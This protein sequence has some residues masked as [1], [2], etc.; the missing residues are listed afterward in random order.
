VVIQIIV[1][2]I[3]KINKIT[4]MIKKTFSQ[5][6]FIITIFFAFNFL[7]VFSLDAEKISD[8]S[9]EISI[10]EIGFKLP[11]VTAKPQV[12]WHWLNGHISSKA[13]TQDLE[14][15]KKT[16]IGG[17][18]LF[19]VSEG[20]PE[21][22][23]KYMSD[24]WWSLLK[25]TKAE[26]KR[27]GLE[28]GFHNG[29]GW[30]SSGG[31]WVT[32]DKAMQEVVWT[33]KKITGPLAFD[34]VLE[35]N[36]AAIGIDRDMARNP[37]V[38]KRY[39]VA[40]EIVEGYYNDIVL[41]AFP[42]PKREIKGTPYLI[43]DWKAKSGYTKMNSYAI[44]NRMAKDSDLIDL[45]QII[46]L[47][48]KLDSNGRLKWDVPAGN[49]TII[50]FGY[51]PT[52]RSNHPAPPAGK[53]LEI[54]KLSKE[55]VDF[56][57]EKSISKIIAAGSKEDNKTLQHILI[58]SYEVGH[59]NWNSTF[60]SDFKKM[61][62]YSLL[63]YLPAL[64][65]RVVENMQTSEKFL[66]DFR[67][68]ISE[69]ITE[70]YYSHFASLAEKNGLSLSAEAY[71][72]FGNINDFDASGKV[73]TPM[74]EWWASSNQENHTATAKLAASTA[75]TY[76]RKLAGAE[77]FTG[78][79]KQ[80]FEESPRSLK[81]EGDFF[82][83]L[84]I[85]QFNLHGF[86]HDPYNIP[87]GLGLGTYGSRFDRR[88]TWC[89]YA[90]GWFDYLSRCQYMLQQGKFKAD[91]LYYVGED[92]PLISW[93]REKLTPA[94]PLGYDYDF[95]NQE[96]LKQLVVKKGLIVLP[97]GMTYRVLILP[98]NQHMGLGA[99]K[100]IEHLVASGATIVGS[101]PLRTP[102]LEGGQ[103]AEEQFKII[104]GRLWGNCDGKSITENKYGKGKIYWGKT[105][106]NI[107]AEKNIFP[108]LSFKI[109]SNEKFGVLNHSVSGIEFIHRQLDG[110]DFY[111]VSNQ[112]DKA[113]LVE[114]TFRVNS[115]LP[116]LWYPETGRVEVASEFRKT[117]D[118]RMIVIL[119]L[120][121]S[122]SV[123]VVFRKPLTTE[124]GIVS[125]TKNRQAGDV[126]IR[127]ENDKFFLNTNVAGDFIIKTSEGESKK[128][129]VKEVPSPILLIGPWKVSFPSESGAP[130]HIEMS[131]LTSLA[132]NTIPEIKYFSGTAIYDV[133]VN[134]PSKML[135]KGQNIVL[136]LGDVQV[137]SEV[138]V[139]GKSLGILWK[140][141]YKISV[142]DFL[143]K[144][145]NAIQVKVANQWVNR[146]IGDQKLPDDCEWTSNTGSTAKGLG[147]A[148][149]PD[150]VINNT[151][152]PS[153]QRK[154]FVS[155]QWP[156]LADKEVL[157]SG[158][159]G[160]V[161]LEVEVEKEL[162]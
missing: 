28:M 109:L 149:I 88:N 92:A 57:W 38:N 113:K 137:I 157:P 60:E 82:M 136:D 21:G 119:R 47:T 67:K 100:Q 72:Q 128:L 58:D 11:P 63:Q 160:P 59:Q 147:L 133:E 17:F 161:R 78:N 141:P 103:L 52:G 84:G 125:V 30:S 50:R 69:L 56:Y 145:K 5:T 116:E 123:F 61:R 130:E 87:P 15:M 29:A 37:E 98:E 43:K 126:T 115:M 142:T 150:W 148:K 76:N 83:C 77:A 68:T 31:P 152:R 139:N 131:S 120:E 14:S 40:R 16:G 42:T 8:K 105:L 117:D 122:E 114:V 4:D 129:S 49:W 3:N 23:V 10:L 155:W 44:D 51:Q 80:I 159:I 71:G 110:K 7:A 138:F 95:C 146:L 73:H 101:K 156:H 102:G 26:A 143:H 104:S 19:N 162:K 1:Y 151:P 2:L 124:N 45:S 91:F 144:G 158:L 140:P 74:A 94:L 46:D 154:A 65:G 64:T 32:P 22:P 111:F 89:P 134:I 24:E 85:N 70:N 86:A 18:T 62:G 97:N 135:L 33:E 12:W 118:G 79:P 13:I 41:L 121:Q 96:I 107:S 112:H 48:S 34:S 53:G 90:H 35:L 39:Y 99:L 20:T 75:H 108:D 127:R 9:K 6:F 36:K 54:D 66:W 25:H 93:I 27:L 106:E 81:A 132:E 55:A 153:T